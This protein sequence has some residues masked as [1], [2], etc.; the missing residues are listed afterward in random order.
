MPT[1]EVCLRAN[2]EISGY[3]IN[4]STLPLQLP[5]TAT[6]EA[7][8]LPITFCTVAW[9]DPND[10]ITVVRHDELMWTDILYGTEGEDEEDEEEA[11]QAG[12]DGAQNVET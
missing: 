8:V 3:I 7:K 11:D 4:M 10:S 5:A 6:E 1:I 9:N 2:P 12:F